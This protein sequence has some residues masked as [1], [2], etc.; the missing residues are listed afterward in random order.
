MSRTRLRRAGTLLISTLLVMSAASVAP[1]A[2]SD[3]PEA[4]VNDLFEAAT[5]GDRST[6]GQFVCE[7]ERE[8]V[9]SMFDFEAEMGL[10][11]LGDLADA[12]SMDIS[13]VSVDVIS[14]DGQ[15][16]TAQVR[17]TM[18]MS[19]PEDD[20]E[21]LVR[22]MLEADGESV[23][24]E[25]LEFMLPLMSTALN[26]RLPIDEEVTFVVE[27][28][29]WLVCG[30]L[31]EEPEEPDFGFE[32]TV[33]NEGLCGIAS[34]D[35]LSALSPLQYDSSSGYETFC[36]YS[37]SDY[38]DY[39]GTTLD[40]QLDQD[41]ETVAP[42]YGAT[43]QVEVGGA[44]A[45]AA[46]P[47]G[48]GNQLLTQVGE[49]VLFVSVSLSENPPDGV[50]WLTQATL[51][52]E[53]LMPRLAEFRL[54][55]AGP[56]PEPTPEPTPEISLCESLSMLELNELTGLGFDESTG[57]STSCDY[58]ST[59]GDPGYDFVVAYINE[60][61]LDDYRLWLPEPEES[62]VAGLPAFI[63]DHQLI[64]ELPD[65]GRVLDISVALSG[66]ASPMTATE[67]AMLIAERLA[68]A[69]PPAEASTE[70]PTDSSDVDLDALMAALEDDL[71]A[72]EAGVDGGPLEPSFVMC[73]YV[74]LDAVNALGILEYDGSSGFFDEICVLSQSDFTAGYSDL[75]IFK[76]VFSIEEARV[77]YPDGIDM[78]VAGLPALDSGSELRV[79][80]SAGP[81]VFVPILPDAAVEAGMQPTDI[82]T[83][84]AELVVAAIE[85]GAGTE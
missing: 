50:D 18:V 69:V 79:A 21:E 23:S 68:P 55:L 56:P 39:H 42:Y 64:V 58:T 80:T 73:D 51:V 60:L 67:V 46:G 9:T 54:E 52:T 15:T 83:P 26:S 84:V 37:T 78:T 2:A 65:G 28:G 48:Y 29:E 32:P 1:V 57:S 34:P 33:S 31:V 35:E 38:R 25:D 81:I 40:F 53:L 76:D 49:D 59:D 8:T 30:G 19:T 10:D 74:D 85:A 24:D 61:S 5:T 6:V 20:T 62:I 43:E 7:E 27:D 70:D 36:T 45:F 22:R 17:A 44:T 66:D 63:T 4:A 16:A 3:S 47:D 75:S 77:A 14:D 82:S 72:L 13:D 71:A 11:G 41:V 12:I